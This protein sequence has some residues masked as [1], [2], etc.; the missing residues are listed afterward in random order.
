MSA[1]K[2]GPLVL[3]ENPLE[4]FQLWFDEAVKNAVP[5]PIVMTLA[6]ATTDGRPSARIV[7][8]KGVVNGHFV[9]FTNYL[10]RKG[11][12]L[13]KN[14]HASLLFFWQPMHRQVRID[15]TVEKVSEAESDEYFATRPRGSQIGAWSSPQS[16]PIA[17]RTTLHSLTQQTEER[18]GEKAVPRPAFWG[19]YRVRP[20]RIEFWE[21]REFRLHERIVFEAIPGQ[22]G[23]WTKY[24]VAP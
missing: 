13:E 2:E 1:L 15:G 5:D 10:S 8:L 21:E 16:R 24:R 6:T 14:P 19:G 11:L 22:T 12:E 7:L 20:E 17:D 9:F 23:Q 18:F 4:A 3:P